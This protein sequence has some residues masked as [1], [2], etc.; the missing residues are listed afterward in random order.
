MPQLQRGGAATDT[1]T[2]ITPYLGFYKALKK[3]GL[4]TD[5]SILRDLRWQKE[6]D[7]DAQKIN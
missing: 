6:V 4:G 5:A 2:Q 7:G 1:T 3:W